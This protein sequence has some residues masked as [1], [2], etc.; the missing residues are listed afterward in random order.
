MATHTQMLQVHA[1]VWPPESGLS[2]EYQEI[3]RQSHKPYTLPQGDI[4]RKYI[5]KIENNN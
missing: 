4:K 5:L 2:H 3:Q 1:S